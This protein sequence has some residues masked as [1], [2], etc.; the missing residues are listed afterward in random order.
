MPAGMWIG[1]F[2]AFCATG[3]VIFELSGFL[4]FI[5]ID[6]ANAIIPPKID[7][8]ATLP[9]LVILIV[10]VIGF[11]RKS[12]WS[13]VSSICIWPVIG[14]YSVFNNWWLEGFVLTTIIEILI[15]IAIITAISWR[16][17][18]KRPNVV[19]YFTVNHRTKEK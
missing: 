4:G 3:A 16:Y 19:S 13:K 2:F 15:I 11:F 7:F 5:A 1:A 14:I 9:V 6:Y 10:S 17:F 18:F 8:I 12:Q